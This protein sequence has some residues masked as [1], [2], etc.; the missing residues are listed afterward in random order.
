MSNGDKSNA[1]WNV[2]LTIAVV[3]L[4]TCLGTWA[5]NGFN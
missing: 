4:I 3:L 2:A 5:Y 1:K